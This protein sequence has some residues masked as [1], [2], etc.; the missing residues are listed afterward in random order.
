MNASAYPYPGGSGT[1]T[2]TCTVVFKNDP[3]TQ[4]P[5]TFVCTAGTTPLPSAVTRAAGARV[6]IS[7]T[8]SAPSWSGGIGTFSANAV[9][10]RADTLDGPYGTVNIGVAPQDKEG[11]K[12]SSADMH[13]DAD[14]NGSF[15]RVSLGSTA[16]RFGRLRLFNALGPAQLDLPVPMRTEYW[17][18]ATFVTNT[19]DS[20]TKLPSPTNNVLLSNYVGGITSA[21]MPAGNFT[22]GGSFS[23][24]VGSLVLKKPTSTPGAKGSV[25]VC[26]DLSS[27]PA[28][29]TS[30]ACALTSAGLPWLQ[31]RWSSSAGYNYDPKI[32]ATFGVYRGAPIIYLR[33]MY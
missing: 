12:L 31:G 27:D 29:P 6:S 10:E 16:L 3:V 1:P 18:G 7:G 19:D 17:N 4:N 28:T 30:A 23:G 8:P 20:C 11:V 5:T 13:L 15:E 24:G 26:V 25:D 14:N 21:N 22:A 33:E 2:G 9:L 32:R